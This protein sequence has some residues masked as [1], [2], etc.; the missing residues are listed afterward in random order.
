MIIAY[1]VNQYPLVGHNLIQREI[2][3][4]E[5]C[6]LRVAR[7]LI[8]SYS[9]E[10]VDEEEKLKLEKIQVVLRIGIIGLLWVLFGVAITKL[11]HTFSVFWLR[12]QARGSSRRGSLCHLTDWVKDFVLFRWFFDLAIANILAHFR[13]NSTT[14]ETLF[15]QPELPE[16]V[17][18]LGRVS[19]NDVQQHSLISRAMVQ[20]SLAEGL[21]VGARKALRLERPVISTD[22]TGF[23][24]SIKLGDR[25][26]LVSPGLVKAFTEVMCTALPLLR[27]KRKSV[28]RIEA[29]RVV[30]QHEAANNVSQ[31]SCAV[32]LQHQAVLELGKRCL[33]WC[34][35]TQHPHAGEQ[36]IH[37]LHLR[38]HLSGF[39][40]RLQS[41]HVIS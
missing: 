12:L 35:N 19:R 27:E 18:G 25:G 14:I 33:A 30:G 23:S 1:L 16:P 20:P 21:P 38:H 2:A 5:A 8:C 36:L 24:E 28:G 10:R 39:F 37:R 29:W 40:P 32:S 7:L 34:L 17:E 13:T 4:V 3:R 41:N 15:A 31:E 11:A 26:W 22:V 6:G 9:T